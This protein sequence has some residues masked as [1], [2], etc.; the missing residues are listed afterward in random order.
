MT[1]E[2]HAPTAHARRTARLRL[3][4]LPLG[5]ALG[6][7][8]AA[9]K[10]EPV[11]FADDFSAESLRFTVD[12]RPDEDRQTRSYEILDDR[13]RMTLS[14][15]GEDNQAGAEID[16]WGRS[17]LLTARISLDEVNLPP[18]D[19]PEA[20]I[21]IGGQFW[22]DM[23]DGG[24]DGRTGDVFVQ[25]QLR[26]YGDGT[27]DARLCVDRET[28]ADSGDSEGV[29]LF[30]GGANCDF[31]DD[32]VLELGAE[33]TL[34]VSVDRAAGV[35][36]YSIDDDVRTVSL[37]QPVFTPAFDRRGVQFAQGGVP[38]RA[39][40][41]VHAI[42]TDD[43]FQNFPTDPPVIGPYRPFFDLERAGTSL[44]V[45]DG[46]A[47]FEVASSAEEQGRINLIAQGESDRIEAV[48][49]LSSE[50][51]FVA[52]P[53]GDTEPTARAYL[54]F[55]SYNDTAE[56]GFN[57]NEGN[58]FAAIELNRYANGMPLIEYCLVRSNT[59]DFSDTLDLLAD[60]GRD[61]TDSGI[62]AA[63]D[64]PYAATL[65]LDR[66]AGTMRFAVN[67]SEL[68]YPIATPIFP[69]EDGRFFI[70][71]GP[72]AFNGSNAIVYVDDYRT[73]PDAPL[74]SGAA[75]PVGTGDEPDV[76]DPDPTTAGEGTG[77]LDT[78]NGSS[79]GGGCSIGGHGGDGMTWLLGLL[80]TAAIVLRRR[81]VRVR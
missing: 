47:R 32:V 62:E 46:R 20:R 5:L 74:V 58:V 36:T 73:S 52:G 45:V 13:V 54:G 3:A 25:L 56:G 77:T 79:G 16:A 55:T 69:V 21:R 17:D 9:V 81:C 66:E 42:G 64:T 80:A 33:Y 68:V 7:V 15:T 18:G 26:M 12:D 1:T 59:A 61:C 78:A 57:A 44:F 71:T 53:D 49:E 43:Y 48:L 60:G 29:P 76:Q 4:A 2:F 70:G 6:L 39:V 14:A 38:G 30:E 41:S 34:S 10:A 31:F 22:N 24:F 11:E 23:A 40:A 50:S 75:S 8:S 72:R 65:E 37:G 35:L 27:Q 19:E 28:Q 63:L 67:E 51:T